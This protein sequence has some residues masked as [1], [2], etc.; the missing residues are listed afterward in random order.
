MRMGTGTRTALA[1]AAAAVLVAGACS[2]SP[3]GAPSPRPSPGPGSG[4]L[5]ST[6]APSLS[7]FM[8]GGVRG[9]APPPTIPP[10]D[11]PYPYTTPTP[12]AEPTPIDGTYIR[13]LD[14]GDTGPLPQGLP[15]RCQ[16]CLPYRPD[17][18]VSTL[19]FY[20]GEFYLNHMLSGF[21]TQGHFVVSG[22]RIEI[23]NDPNCPQDRATYRWRETGGTLALTLVGDP[24]DYGDIR[25]FD[26]TRK[27]WVRVNPCV[28]RFRNLWPTAI[29]C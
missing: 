25:A 27:P 20:Q 5:G 16:R 18:G 10:E 12:P 15:W 26:L 19:I 9:L 17:L 6:P 29:A 4:V 28:Y 2:S 1:A 13:I 11:R 23:F 22:D 24:C 21:K 3:P 14:V 7:P 8:Q